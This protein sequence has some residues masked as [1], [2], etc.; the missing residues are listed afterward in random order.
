[1]GKSSETSSIEYRGWTIEPESYLSDCDRWRAGATVY[2]YVMPARR[3][4]DVA[5]HRVLDLSRND[6]AT[7]AE[8]DAEAERLAKVRI[9]QLLAR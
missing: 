6:Y 4:K 5:H 1:M 7:K 9:D 3:D 8:A 2:A